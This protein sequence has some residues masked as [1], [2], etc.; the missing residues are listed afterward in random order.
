[1]WA[2]TRKARVRMTTYNTNLARPVLC[3]MSVEANL[4]PMGYLTTDVY[5]D[6][7]AARPN[8]EDLCGSA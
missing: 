5:V 2:E 7:C 3:A 8:D 4:S 1:M 6:A